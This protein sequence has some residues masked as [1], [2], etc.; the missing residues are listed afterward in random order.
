MNSRCMIIWSWHFG[1]IF[2]KALSLDYFMQGLEYRD[3][4]Q[5]HLIINGIKIDNIRHIL[6]VILEI[7]DRYYIIYRVPGV[8]KSDTIYAI[9]IS[10]CWN[11]NPCKYSYYKC[12]I[13]CHIQAHEVLVLRRTVFLIR[14]F[15]CRWFYGYGH[16]MIV[17]LLVIGGKFFAIPKIWDK[18]FVVALVA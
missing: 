14:N 10:F 9:Y 5:C 11:F 3:W 6:L 4:Y 12:G 13:T 16:P 1:L 8:S 7:L 15:L 17:C 18:G 2:I